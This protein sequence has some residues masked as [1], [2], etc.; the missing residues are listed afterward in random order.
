MKFNKSKCQILYLVGRNNPKCTYKLGD[1]MLDSSIAG[2]LLGVLVDSKL[3]TSQQ[4]VQKARKE[5][6]IQ[7][8]IKHGI[9]AG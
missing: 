1:E 6:H 7:G 8:H 4:C 2:R 3:N 9:A 5:N